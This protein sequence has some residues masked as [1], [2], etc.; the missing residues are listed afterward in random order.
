MGPL[1]GISEIV[2]AAEAPLMPATS[3]SFSVSAESTKAMTWVS[4]LNPSGKQRT[5]RAVD[6]PAGQNL[7]FTGT[8][9]ALDK[10][11]RNASASVGVFAVIDG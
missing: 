7:A 11:A 5:D 9:F 8:P 3:G 4:H 2:N 6:L 1:N 10:A